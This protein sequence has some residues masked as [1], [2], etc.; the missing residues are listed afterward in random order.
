MDL[1][2]RPLRDGANVEDI[3]PDDVKKLLSGIICKIAGIDSGLL[4]MDLRIA[5]KSIEDGALTL[6][7][8]GKIRFLGLEIDVPTLKFVLTEER[9]MLT[10]ESAQII[11]RI[12]GAILDLVQDEIDLKRR[13]A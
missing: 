8:G 2:N 13:E 6:V 12:A 3:S 9:Y 7:L 1:F 11:A 4:D 10:E 5:A